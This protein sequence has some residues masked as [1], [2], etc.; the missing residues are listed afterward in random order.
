ML[1]AAT[2]AARH[3]RAKWRSQV[4]DAAAIA[5]PQSGGG[6][7]GEERLSRDRCPPVGVAVWVAMG[8]E[9]C[10]AIGPV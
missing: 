8:S 3:L 7:G 1:A 6:L 4:T 5:A 9:P 2:I 10:S